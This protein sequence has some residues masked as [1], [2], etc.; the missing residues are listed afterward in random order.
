[1]STSL[2]QVPAATLAHSQGRRRPRP[3]TVSTTTATEPLVV[4]RPLGGQCGLRLVH[5]LLAH[6]L[7]CGLLVVHRPRC[8]C[9]QRQRLAVHLRRPQRRAAAAAAAQAAVVLVV[10]LMLGSQS[11]PWCEAACLM[12]F[13]LPSGNSF[14]STAGHQ[15]D[16]RSRHS[17]RQHLRHLAGFSWMMCHRAFARILLQRKRRQLAGKPWTMSRTVCGGTLQRRSLQCRMPWTLR[18]HSRPP[19]LLQKRRWIHR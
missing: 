5:H 17:W 4:Q 10:V 1:M 8:L 18:S 19:D 2:S 15:S 16:S 13:L 7:E 6:L 9:R 14:R 12:M 11:P 3:T